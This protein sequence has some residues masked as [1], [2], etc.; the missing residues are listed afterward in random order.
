[1]DVTALAMQ[2]SLVAFM[3]GSLAGVG[4]G[5][6]PREV[7]APLTHGRFVLLTLAL[8]WL[9]GPVIAR[10]LLWAIPLDR[11]Y[12][13]ALLLA[14]AP[15]APFAPAM[16]RRAGGDPAYV[17]AFMVLTAVVTVIVM[18]IGVPLLV[19]GAAV[20]AWDL[21][22]PLVIFV[23]APML[24]GTAVRGLWPHAAMRLEPVVTAIA[25]VATVVMLV[26]VI[27]T[28]GR[29]VLDAVGSHA[30]LVQL[31]FLAAV[32]L[33]ADLAGAALGAPQRNV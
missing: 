30:I 33:V 24:A 16:M 21:A 18:P 2:I 15:C 31:I 28:Y 25:R 6:A 12:A 11:P 9:A 32:T 23:L 8:G 7:L 29:G 19:P 4:L 13:T 22:R 3:I 27:I 26:L 20:S 5:V 1:M 14:L 17:A 10:L